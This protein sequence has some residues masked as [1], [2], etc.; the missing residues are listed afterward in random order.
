MSEGLFGTA[1]NFA[2]YGVQDDTAI[3]QKRFIDEITSSYG[4]HSSE[5]RK[6][7]D[8]S[9]NWR[10]LLVPASKAE[11]KEIIFNYLQLDILKETEAKDLDEAFDRLDKLK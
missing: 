3:K 4:A 1:H 10:N 7:Y 6:Y 11:R 5:L 2:T 8:S 9:K